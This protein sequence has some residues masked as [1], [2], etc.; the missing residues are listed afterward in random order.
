MRTLINNKVSPYRDLTVLARRRVSTDRPS[1][2][3]AAGRPPA[4]LQ[5][6][7]IED[8]R[9]TPTEA[10]EQNNTGPLGGPVISL[11]LLITPHCYAYRKRR[12][13]AAYC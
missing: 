9:Q 1:M 10:S 4:A 5:T 11:L 12:P 2:R 8:I 3:P 13:N 7:T 6:T